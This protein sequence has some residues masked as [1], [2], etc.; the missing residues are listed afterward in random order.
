MSG[1]TDTDKAILMTAFAKMDPVALAI[2]L[3][4]IWALILLLATSFLLIKGSPEG[5][6]IGGHLELLHI[7]LPGYQVSWSGG[8]LGALYMF[9]IGGVTGYILAVLWNLTHYIYV[10]MIVIRSAWWRM[11]AD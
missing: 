7:Y 3:G 9:F 4:S 10:V 11:M 8:L 1:K 5:Y 2:A 6:E